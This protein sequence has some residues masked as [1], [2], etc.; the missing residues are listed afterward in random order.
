MRGP[1]LA[2]LFA[3]ACSR[4]AGCRGKPPP[5][6]RTARPATG[7]AASPSL[8]AADAPNV[9]LVSLDTVRADHIGAWGYARDT[10]PTLDAVAAEGG[11]FARSWAQAP[12]TDGTHGSLFSGRYV[13]HHAK[14]KQGLRLPDDEW[15]LAEH[16][17]HHGYRTFGLATSIK[18]V[19]EANFGQGFATWELFPD[20]PKARRSPKVLARLPAL[21]ADESAPFFG[22]VHLFDAHAPYSPPEPHRS[23]F[24][25]GRSPAISPAKTID[26]IQK[27]RRNKSVPARKRQTLID[28]Y[29]GSLRYLDT[30][31]ATLMALARSTRRPTIVV[32]FS[33]HGEAFGEHGYYGHDNVMWEEVLRVPVVVWA[34]GRVQA[35]AVI[36]VPT[37]TVDLYPTLSSLAGLPL[38]AGLDGFDLA[39]ALA[40]TPGAPLPERR[41]LVLQD[42]ND[43]AL[44]TET[45]DG[46]VKLVA[47]L[48]P[49]RLRLFDLG[50]DPGERVNAKERLPSVF[51]ALREAFLALG[52]N[53]PFRNGEARA[54]LSDEENEELRALGYMD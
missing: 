24:L 10:M 27:N 32:F 14:L 45:A 48:K 23:A 40:G 9:L 46:L 29:D 54:P 7:L 5:A 38:P 25:D 33:D 16:F 31:I 6:V 20:G 19:P 44:V 50:A 3:L 36:G 51:T 52:P 39:P 8:A 12:L 49:R 18:F 43:W 34:P 35:G 11:R 15:S 37:Q 22:F 2:L 47:H 13:I 53:R 1:L 26:F 42:D 30:H 4:P 21:T 17:A 28:L 41:V